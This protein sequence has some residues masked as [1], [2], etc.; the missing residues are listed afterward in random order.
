MKRESK[1]Q[2]S[3]LK[4]K[5]TAPAHCVD[6]IL[7]GSDQ[8]IKDPFTRRAR[9]LFL[10]VVAVLRAHRRERLHVSRLI[11]MRTVC[12]V[13]AGRGDRCTHSAQRLLPGPPIDDTEYI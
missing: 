12:S 9:L 10:D 5:G 2:S 13:G 6:I 4:G 3:E 11:F 8:Q 1:R 7:L